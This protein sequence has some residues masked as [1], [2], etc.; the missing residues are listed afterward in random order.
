MARTVAVE[1]ESI[2]GVSHPGRAQLHRFGIFGGSNGYWRTSLLRQVRMHGFMLTEDIDSSLRVIQAGGRI[3]VDPA[4][5][6]RELAPTTLQALWKQ[7]MR[8][9][10]GWF[11]VSLRHLRPA[12]R[13]P[14][15]TLRQKLGFTFLLGW[16][17]V[18]PWLSLQVVPLLGFFSWKA[19]SAGQLN[20][21]I[22]IFVLT[23]LYTLSVGPGQTYFAWR[24][25]TTEVRGRP[26]WFLRYL[27]VSTF[28]YTEM[29]NLISRVAQIKEAVGERQWTVTTR[30]PR[31]AM[32]GPAGN[33]TH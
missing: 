19:G 2:Y 26:G 31:S 10:Q 14:S 29:K 24:V 25:A 16:R 3:A 20:W 1:F 4:L 23:T 5:I 6:S 21:F 18:Y 30:N 28:F 13:S 17:E 9:A 27:V 8:W 33:T 15:L 11:Q 12:L 22:P 32:R 7:R